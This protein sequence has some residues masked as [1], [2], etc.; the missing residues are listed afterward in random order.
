MQQ[1]DPAFPAIGDWT[2]SAGLWSRSGD[3]TTQSPPLA[4]L[5]VTRAFSAGRETDLA[6][7]TKC[8]KPPA[9]DDCA[10]DRRPGC[11][12]RSLARCTGRLCKVPRQDAL[13]ALYPHV[14]GRK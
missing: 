13:I 8:H 4:T 14:E 1:K 7:F 5:Q 3:E 10:R 11:S 9:P 12:Y 6:V 2:A